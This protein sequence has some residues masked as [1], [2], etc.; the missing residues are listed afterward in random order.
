MRT[1]SMILAAGLIV[2]AFLSAGCKPKEGPFVE[3]IPGLKD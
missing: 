3:G 2:S 1:A